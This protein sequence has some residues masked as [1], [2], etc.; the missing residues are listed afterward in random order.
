LALV[1]GRGKTMP[2]LGYS[3]KKSGIQI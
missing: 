1:L 2:D 3:S